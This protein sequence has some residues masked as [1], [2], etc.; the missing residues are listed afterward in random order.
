VEVWLESLVAEELQVAE[1]YR[2]LSKA[3]RERCDRIIHPAGRHNYI[4][5]RG[6]LRLL[7][8]RY[9]SLAPDLVEISVGDRGKPQVE[10]LE[11]NLSH[12]GDLVAYVLGAVPVGIDV[13]RRRSLNMDGLVRRFFT[14]PE[15]EEWQNLPVAE[16]ETAFFQAWTIKEAYV[17]ATGQGLAGDLA[18]ISVQLAPPWLWRSPPADWQLEVL[19]LPTAYLGAVVIT[20]PSPQLCIHR[21]LH[22]R[23]VMRN[24]KLEP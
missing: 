8:G 19:E 23:L 3:E 5:A 18:N 16:R 24:F 14:P 10:G 4:V 20:S 9:L 17:K 6:R 11:F 21:C 1:F 22:S 12:S 15:K 13:E 7:L 2:L